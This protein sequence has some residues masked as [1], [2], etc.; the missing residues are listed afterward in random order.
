MK[1]Y[2]QRLEARKGK[3]L[4]NSILAC[5]YARAVYYMLNRGKVFEFNKLARRAA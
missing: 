2:Y 5:K 1:K 3:F 4:A